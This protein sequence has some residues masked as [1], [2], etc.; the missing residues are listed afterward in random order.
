V[1]AATWVKDAQLGPGRFFIGRKRRTWRYEVKGD[2]TTEFLLDDKGKRYIP[3]ERLQLPVSFAKVLSA[4]GLQGM[5]VGG[6]YTDLKRPPGM[7]RD[8]HWMA[9]LVLLSRALVL[10]DI[11]VYRLCRKE[12][13]EGGPPEMVRT[14]L[15]RLRAIEL[16][17][18]RTLD[19]ALAQARL[20]AARV[21]I[22]MPLLHAAQRE[23]EASAEG[24]A[25]K[26]GADCERAHIRPPKPKK[27][28]LRRIPEP[29]PP[30]PA[31]RRQQASQ[32][33]VPRG[34]ERHRDWLFTRQQSGGHCGMYALNHALQAEVFT[35]ARME[36]ACDVVIEESRYPSVEGIAAAPERRADHARDDGSGWYSDQVL[37]QALIA[38]TDY[39]WHHTPLHVNA[40]LITLPCTEGAIVNVANAH[41]VALRWDADGNRVCVLDSTKPEPS[42]LA[43]PE[44]VAYIND[45]RESYALV[46]R[47]ALGWP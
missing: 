46:D 31:A 40:D 45:W 47:Q 11:L 8:E 10:D 44:Y 1:P 19:Q 2:T 43:F 4:Y 24:R 3:V 33:G 26:S 16:D 5:T 25:A 23:T 21:D 18:L 7:K 36:R 9:C 6:I 27:P 28:R 13:L 39:R 32:D 15:M 38:H 42:F 22:T 34:E 35:P 17:T 29:V 12:H 41:W 14:E 37:A 20:Y 30:G